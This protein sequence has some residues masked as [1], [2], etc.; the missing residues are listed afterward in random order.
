VL[1]HEKPF[2][3]VN[4]SGKHCNW[5]MSTDTGENLLD[6]SLKPETNYRF[7]LFLVATLD[8]VHKHGGLLRAAIASASNEHRL[9]AQEAPPGIISAFLGDHLTEV[10]NAVETSREIKNF[11][12]PGLASVQVGGTV[13]DLKI[14]SMPC[15]ARDLTDRNRT[16]PFAF[17][18]NKFEFRAVGS[19]Q[20]TSFPTMLINA[21]VAD[22]LNRVADS[23]KSQ[24]G[25]RTEPSIDDILTVVRK[26]TKSSKDI[27]F[28]GNNYSAE[29]KAE[30]AKR[31]L[32]DIDNCPEAFKKLIEP[33][34]AQ[35]LTS[36]GIMTASELNSRYQILLEKYVKDIVIEA[37]TL[38]A[39][40]LQAILPAAYTF[41]KQL[42][43]SLVAQ[44]TIGT[45]LTTLAEKKTMDILSPLISVL[46]ANTEKLRESIDKLNGLDEHDQPAFANG[47]LLKCINHCRDVADDIQLVIPN[48]LWPY[49]KYL[50]LLF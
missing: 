12:V 29:W 19:K 44:K 37:E 39:M 46:Y 45:D 33:S 7:L 31:G 13:L 4:G 14:H 26:F 24:M 42:A 30:A 18:G 27:R 10:L 21:M 35:L 16:S 38:K 43:D 41:R 40:S 47:T 48:D 49:P 23:L 11:S 50:D 15:I 25:T 9:G 17:T 22:G 20:N 8:A 6:P 1:F 32:P 36:Q 2:K 28:E 3:G 5:S 34:H